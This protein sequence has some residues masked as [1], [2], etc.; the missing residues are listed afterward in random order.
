[1]K[2]FLQNRWV[3]PVLPVIGRV[4]M[5][6]AFV[7]ALSVVTGNA[8]ADDIGDT[9]TSLGGYWTDIK[10]LAIGVLL[11]ILGRRLLKKI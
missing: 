9:V 3:K 2:K 11:F 7:F 8:C 4:L 1:M 6:L 10:L 5:V